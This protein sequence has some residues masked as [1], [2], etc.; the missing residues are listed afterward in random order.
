MKMKA[1]IQTTWIESQMCLFA[2]AAITKYSRMAGLN[3]RHLLS[4]SFG[5]MP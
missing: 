4:H 2:L 5:A 1:V 3:N